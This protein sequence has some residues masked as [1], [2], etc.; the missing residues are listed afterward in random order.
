MKRFLLKIRGFTMLH[1]IAVGAAC[2]AVVATAAALTT[3]VLLSKGTVDPPPRR[4]YKRILLGT[5]GGL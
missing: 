4:N 2:A 5:D 1:P 3:V